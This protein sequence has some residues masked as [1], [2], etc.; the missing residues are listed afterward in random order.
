MF[1]L[2]II[3]TSFDRKL[4]SF[5]KRLVGSYNKGTYKMPLL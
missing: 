1:S 3:N 2:R 4:I 5:N